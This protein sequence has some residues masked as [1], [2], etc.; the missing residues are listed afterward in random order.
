MYL[1]VVIALLGVFPIA[2]ILVEYFAAPGGRDLAFLIGKWFVFWSVGVR[3]LLAGAR[4]VA[5]PGFTAKTI[6]EV[7]DAA[8]LPIVRELGFGNLSIGLLGAV[9]L[10]RPDWIAPAALAGG[11]YYGLAGALHVVRDNRN[12][13]ENIAMISD[14]LIFI[15]LAGYLA[16]ASLGHA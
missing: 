5:D 13:T 4:Q 8:A 1:V 7:E 9:T 16:A 11:L 12:G 2:S 6:F 15:V 10:A 14:I 3:L